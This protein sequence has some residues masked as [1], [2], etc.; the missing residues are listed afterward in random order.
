MKYLQDGKEQLNKEDFQ[1]NPLS[2]SDWIKQTQDDPCDT[3][4]PAQ[5]QKEKKDE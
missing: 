3:M 4:M 5:K 1:R 2:E